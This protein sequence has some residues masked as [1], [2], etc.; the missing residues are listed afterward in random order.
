MIRVPQLPVLTGALP[1]LVVPYRKRV[2]LVVG[3]DL[4]AQL[5]RGIIGR[6]GRWCVRAA[7]N[8]QGQRCLKM[9]DSLDLFAASTGNCAA[10]R[11]RGGACTYSVQEKSR[12][13][14]EKRCQ[15]DYVMISAAFRSWVLSSHGTWKW[16]LRRR[17]DMTDHKGIVF[18]LRVK[19]RRGKSAALHARWAL[20]GYDWGLTPLPC[21]MGP[22]CMGSVAF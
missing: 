13:R 15:L 10:P 14:A 22:T 11:R 2:V 19:L 9:M 1:V 21:K 7:G 6:T 4:N 16:C 17:G 18:R 5:P 3:G 20:A 12:T 8:A